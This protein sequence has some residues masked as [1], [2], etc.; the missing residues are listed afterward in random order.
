MDHAPVIPFINIRTIAGLPL[1]T[2]LTLFLPM[3]LDNCRVTSP[4]DSNSIFTH[5]FR[6]RCTS[7]FNETYVCH[8]SIIST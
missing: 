8:Y 6:H 5:D 4:D 7:F 3:I 2:T 1:L